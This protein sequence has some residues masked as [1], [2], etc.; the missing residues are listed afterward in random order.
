M[1]AQ[2]ERQAKTD[3]I[4]EL[5]PFQYQITTPNNRPEVVLDNLGKHAVWDR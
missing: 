1:L 5:D 2:I 4:Y 3:G